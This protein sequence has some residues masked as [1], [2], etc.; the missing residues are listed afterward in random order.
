MAPAPTGSSTQGMPSAAA[1]SAARSMA[2]TQGG[3]RVPMFTVSAEEI[4]T[5][6][7]TSSAACTIAGDAPMAS[8][9][10]AATSIAT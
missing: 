5:N 8:S 6:S 9:A 7:S 4:A 3:D 2:A 10:F 1:R